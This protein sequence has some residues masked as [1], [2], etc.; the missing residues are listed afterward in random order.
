VAVTPSSL[1]L[2]AGQ[3]AKIVASVSADT[4]G[5]KSGVDWS[6][7]N[8]AVATVTSDGTVMAKAPGTSTIIARSRF[9]TAKAGAAQVTVV[10][11]ITDPMLAIVPSSATIRVDSTIQLILAPA[12]AVNWKSSAPSIASVDSTGLARGIL[13]GTAV[14]TAE[15]K[16]DPTKSATSILTIKGI[17]Q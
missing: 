16:S 13:P 3:S 10:A 8:E 14:I 15:V 6:S 11:E 5:V 7:T 4:T 1:R 2:T 17:N 12:V 9:N